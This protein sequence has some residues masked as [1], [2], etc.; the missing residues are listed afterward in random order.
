MYPEDPGRPID[1]IEENA[2]GVLL[3]GEMWL[4]VKNRYPK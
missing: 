1:F 2:S 3:P 4:W